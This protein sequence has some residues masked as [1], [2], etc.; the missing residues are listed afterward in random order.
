MNGI[1]SGSPAA[2]GRDKAL[3]TVNEVYSSLQGESSFAGRP[4]I[5]VR[6]TGCALRCQWCDSEFTFYEGRRR[7]VGDVFRQVVSYGVPLVEVTGGEPLLQDN[8]HL[9]IA[10]LLDEG[11][12]VLVETGGDQDI[13]KVDERAVVI[14]DVKCPGSGMME[15]MDW[16]NIRRLRPHHEVKFVLRDRGDYEWA[17]DTLSRHRL[18]ERCS[19][20]MGCVH[21]ELEPSDLAEW[22]VE[23]RLPV[24]FQMQMHKMIWHPEERRR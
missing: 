9:L 16:D 23:D 17:R 1:P 22:I 15:K 3:L 11:L 14:M 24:R 21:G 8:V 5:F 13:S 7:P 10:E 4:C 2:R 19:V 18:A 12:T 20:L 6:L